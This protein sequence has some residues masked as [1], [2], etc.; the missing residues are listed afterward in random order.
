[1][2][3]D[4]PDV[5]LPELWA[6]HARF[7][8]EKLAVVC[9]E[10][11]ESWGELYAG[12]NRVANR[13]L[14]AGIGHGDN[15]AVVM[16]NSIDMLHIMYGI[17]R[18]GACVV[19]V[20]ML[21]REEQVAVLLDDSQSVALF[22]SP[23]PGALSDALLAS[24]GGIRAD[25]R[26]SFGFARRGWTSLAEWLL[27]VSA[28]PPNVR[29]SAGDDFSI[30]YSSGT[31]GD[32]K[33]ILHTHRA[34]VHMAY[35]NA[36]E[37]RFRHDSIALV[38]TSLYS[39]GSWLM[40]LPALFMGSTLIIMEKFSP[41]G[42][43]QLVADERI[44]HTF[45]VPS[46]F[47]AL[48]AHPELA[49]S[50]LRSLEV[51]LCAG[52]PLREATKEEIRER[53]G[54]GLFELYG[55][56]EGFATLIGPDEAFVRPGSVGRPVL[57]FD[58]RIVN[59]QGAEAAAGE[60][61]EIA[62]FGA[63]LMKGYFRKPQITEEA[64]WRDERGRSFVRSGDIGRLDDEGF[65]YL[66]DRKKDMI[67]SGGFNVFPKDIEAVVAQHPA[68]MDVTVIGVPN[69]KW[70]EIPLA[71]VIPKP[72][73]TF[74]PEELQEWCNARLGKAQQIRHIEIRSEFPRNA[75]GKVLKRVLREPYWQEAQ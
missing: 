68:I 65:L 57:G 27:G 35:S 6:S 43:L 5:L 1:L 28:D 73:A 71:L 36:L 38:T 44:T 66:L 3:L 40:L 59:E 52:S 17:V 34:R 49:G 63:G 48:L 10:G 19:P 70:G 39:N 11:R 23:G 7:R 33:G 26:I 18:A 69:S 45:M 58:L 8:A 20:S 56:S 12:F 62:G 31:T 16:S 4:H 55:F 2:P 60:A 46:Q 21:L 30:I 25:L 74:V 15:V 47:I 64:I 37:L 22:A 13:L 29:Y 42:M 67:L 61:G 24:L 41:Q 75:L 54:T 50:D 32:P 14:A 9:P 51:M 72:G 53:I